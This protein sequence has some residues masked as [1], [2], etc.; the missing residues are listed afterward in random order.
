M[1]ESRQ[2]KDAD[3]RSL[4]P[5]R[6][7]YAADQE[8]FALVLTDVPDHSLASV[9]DMV[10][11]QITALPALAVRGLTAHEAETTATRLRTLGALVEIWDE[12]ASI[13]PPS[14]I[15]TKH[16]LVSVPQ[17][18]NTFIILLDPGGKKIQ[19]I[20]EV[21]TATGLGLKDAKDLVDAAP[22]ILGPFQAQDAAV[23]SEALRK[24]GAECELDSPSV[25][26]DLQVVDV[27][28]TKYPSLAADAWPDALLRLLHSYPSDELPN[29]PVVIATGINSYLA[30]RITRIIDEAGGEAMFEPKCANR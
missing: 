15:A 2:A 26:E 12:T 23:A 28:L 9:C 3:G 29:E 24:A 17:P 16:E 27:V 7:S 11:T 8:R 1:A 13:S 6:L 10:G 30:E 21:R 14:P 18:P 20:K 25:S 19:V 5:G 4:Y 22:S